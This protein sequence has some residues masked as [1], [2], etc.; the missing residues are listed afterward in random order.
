MIRV[1]PI[2]RRALLGVPL[3]GAGAL[4]LG[5]HAGFKSSGAIV[6][7]DSPYLLADQSPPYDQSFA[8]FSTRLSVEPDEELQIRVRA[9]S[10]VDV[11]IYR[12]GWTARGRFG[13]VVA[14]YE[15]VG[16]ASVE[17]SAP[18]LT[19]PIAV[20]CPVPR[21]WSS[22]LYVAVV[23]DRSD[24]TRRRFAPFVVRSAGRPA[25]IVVSVPFTTYHAYNAW[26]GASLYGFNSPNGVA[27]ALPIARPFDVFDGAGFMFYGDW[28]LARWLDREQYCV[29]YITS[30]DLH[31]DQG[32]L[33]GAAVLV[34]AFHD[35][36][37]STP[38]RDTLERFLGTGGNAMFLAANSI[39][40]R[41]R[42]DESAM[43]CHK[44]TSMTDD[45]HPDITATWRSQLIG[46]PESL[47]LG[48]Q[49]GD[50]EFPYGTGFDW[51][52]AADDH[53]LY[54]GT[55]LTNGAT[56]RGLVGYEWDYAPSRLHPGTTVLAHTDFEKANGDRR[57]HNATER[58]HPGGGTVVNVGT[59]YWPRFLIGDDAFRADET[60]QQMTHNMLN[61]LGGTR[62]G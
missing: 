54:E 4:L 37:W 40:W 21:H 45:P 16:L 33:D 60:V 39:Y 50:Y 1:K 49:Y 23:G 36:Y 52:V 47:I 41:I 2:S 14:R 44:A 18:P 31:R 57:V 17:A 3:A 12:I 15:Q 48:S 32:C 61:R 35:E 9:Q 51:T 13:T 22:G 7:P 38:M 30:Y 46:K 8:A 28:Q 19:W 55:G 24:R 43:T 11:E 56:L 59:T 27:R 62:S 20:R 10:E 5:R 29:S 58:V 6:G 42:L 26:G 25:R 34:T 53:W